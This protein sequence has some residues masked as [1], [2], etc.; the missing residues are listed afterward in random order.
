MSSSSSAKSS[1]SAATRRS[2]RVEPAASL[3]AHRRIV[4][5]LAD[6]APGERLDGVELAV[7]ERAEPG[8]E[9]LDLGL[10]HLLGPVAQRD[11]HRGHL[12]GRG[13]AEVALELLVEQRPH[14][15]DLA[16][17]RPA[18]RRRRRRAGRPC[19]AG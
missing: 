9:A 7:V 3:S 15:G 16:L 12:A 5:Q 18:C 1:R 8:A 14:D 13:G 4:Q 11:D 6:D 10:A 19:R 17:A 2:P